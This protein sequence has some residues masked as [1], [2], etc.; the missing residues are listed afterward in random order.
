MIKE[1]VEYKDDGLYWKKLR[2]RSRGKVGERVGH[3]RPDGY[4]LFKHD[5]GRFYE[6]RVIWEMHNGP[7]PDG[8]VI[9]HIDRN[10]R[11]NSIENL[12]VVTQSQNHLNKE[13]RGYWVN[14]CGRYV[15]EFMGK[16]LGSFNNKED[17]RSAYLKAKGAYA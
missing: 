5:G 11:N 16:Y 13:C 3:E 1:Y 17:A 15:A 10:P 2:P 8:L 4:R 14:R 9:D 7:I 6:H 12:R